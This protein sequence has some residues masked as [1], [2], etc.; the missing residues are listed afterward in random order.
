MSFFL[1][2]PADLPPN[3][4]LDRIVAEVARD[5]VS[6]PSKYSDK[7]E[8]VVSNAH[9]RGIDL[10]I[11]VVDKNPGHDSPLRDLATE[12]GHHEHGTVLVLSPNMVGSYSDTISRVKLEAGQDTTYTGDPVVSAQNFVNTIDKPGI[13]WTA[14]TCVLIAGVAIVLAGLYFVKS[15]RSSSTED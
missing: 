10:S 1:P 9:D 5:H 3:V 7:L 4:N 11:V 14:L 2:A 8:S 6:A 15:R 13:P 12:V